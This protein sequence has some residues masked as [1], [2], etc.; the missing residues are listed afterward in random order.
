MP[1]QDKIERKL[2]PEWCRAH[3]MIKGGHPV[4]EVAKVVLSSLAKTLK[5][6][7]GAPGIG[8]IA[9]FVDRHDRG[10]LTEADFKDRYFFDILRDPSNVPEKR[11]YPLCDMMGQVDTFRRALSAPRP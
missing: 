11:W 6:R 7:G 4:A 9:K 8:M 3:R 2:L 10:L 1:D 5:R